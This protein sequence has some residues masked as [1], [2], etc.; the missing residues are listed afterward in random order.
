MALQRGPIP[1]RNMAARPQLVAINECAA[2]L[3]NHKI[4]GMSGRM[5][6]SVAEAQTDRHATEM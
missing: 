2:R 5:G 6:W 3:L 1:P 4:S